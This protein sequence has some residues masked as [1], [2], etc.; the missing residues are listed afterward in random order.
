MAGANAVTKV[1]TKNSWFV[2]HSNLTSNF[3]LL[4]SSYNRI[5]AIYVSHSESQYKRLQLNSNLL[6][7]SRL[8][9]IGQ[10]SQPKTEYTL[11]IS[12]FLGKV[13]KTSLNV[14]IL[15]QD[16]L[17]SQ[18]SINSQISRLLQLSGQVTQKKTQFCSVI[19]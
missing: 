18:P 16:E 4:K 7:M 12:P 5:K 1:L 19:N 10:I 3:P 6:I 9:M 2:I 17:L 14:S 8:C 15:L 13:A 11:A